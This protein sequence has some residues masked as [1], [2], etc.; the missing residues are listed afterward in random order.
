LKKGSG[1]ENNDFKITRTDKKEMVEFKKQILDDLRKAK[2][3]SLG[4]DE[5]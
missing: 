2:R 3:Q 5:E 4:N 1:E